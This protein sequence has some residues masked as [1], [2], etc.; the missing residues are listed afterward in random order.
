M[1]TDKSCAVYTSRSEL[2]SLPYVDN[3]IVDYY[4]YPDE[5]VFLKSQYKFKIAVFEID[6]CNYKQTTI[7]FEKFKNCDYVLVFSMEGVSNVINL[8]KKYD[9]PNF[10]FV[11][12]CYLNFKLTHA[13]IKHVTPH[14]ATVSNDWQIELQ[15]VIIDK[16]APYQKKSY[17]FEIMYGKKRDHRT[18][19]ANWI[20]E[21]NLT[22]YFLQTPYF[23][24]KKHNA[25]NFTYNLDDS[26]FWEDEMIPSANKDYICTYRGIEMNISQVMPFKIYQ[27]SAFSLICETTVDN[28]GSF[29][30]EK[31]AKPIIASRLFVV[32]SGQYYLKNLK[33]LGFKTF[34]N[35]IDESYDSEPD[36][37]KRWSLALEQVEWLCTQDQHKILKAIIPIVLHNQN[38]ITKLP[39]NILEITLQK[40]LLEHQ[41]SYH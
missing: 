41:I 15:S 11:V 6:Y 25:I 40:L 30:T 19:V 23:L 38:L 5:D 1:I 18:Y 39:S 27:Q 20:L 3:N 35:I 37:E 4:D 21:N 17:Y 31:I 10:I 32:I 28:R 29:F 16:L 2:R 33:K 24:E 14:M 36:P 26:T 8:I 34:D 12:N 7:Q 13:Q 9:L 22:P